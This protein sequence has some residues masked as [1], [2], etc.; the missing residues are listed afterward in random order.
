MKQAGA[1][2]TWPNGPAYPI[3]VNSHAYGTT[4]MGTDPASSVVDKWSFSHEVPNLAILGGSTFPVSTGYNPTHT[5]EA[6]AWR[7]GDHIA[8]HFKALAT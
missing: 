7:T 2:E 8:K 5:I 1:S 6:L 4:R 3:A